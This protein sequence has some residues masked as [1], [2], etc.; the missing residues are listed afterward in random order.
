MIDSAYRAALFALYQF[1]IAV[2][3]VLLPLA[4]A[5]SR[6]GLTLPVHR[7]VERLGSAYE[8]AQPN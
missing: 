8:N 3:I 6:V 1:S 4:L 7:M 5:T 2:G